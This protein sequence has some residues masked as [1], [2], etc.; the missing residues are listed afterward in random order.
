MSVRKVTHNQFSDGCTIDGARI[1]DALED[2]ENR[3]N[4]IPLGDLGN[5][6]V[7][8]QYIA[9]F[10]PNVSGVTRDAPFE[11]ST[12]KTSDVRTITGGS[13]PDEFNNPKRFKGIAKTKELD[14]MLVWTISIY[15]KKP[16]I[17]YAV[18]V[19]MVVDNEYDNNFIYDGT[20]GTPRPSNKDLNDPVDDVDVIVSV[21]NPWQLENRALN[22]VIFA[23]HK[24]KALSYEISKASLTINND[25]S[26]SHPQNEV[27]DGIAM[28]ITDLNI[29]IHRDARLR[30]AVGVPDWTDN[31]EP[32]S[33]QPVQKQVWTTVLTFLEELQE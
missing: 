21:D 33:T 17:L 29:P 32:W 24:F 8:T 3:V 4:E 30:F 28:T 12:N 2:L 11:P 10:L 25:M 26:P 1:E 18:D 19:L 31:Y 6:F 23:K 20:G 14:E 13:M 5:R 15:K 27:I 16:V 7:Q 9:S 22:S